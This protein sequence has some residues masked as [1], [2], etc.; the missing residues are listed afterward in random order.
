MYPQAKF[1]QPS[2]S[3][4]FSVPICTTVSGVNFTD[5]YDNNW[6]TTVELNFLFS[7]LFI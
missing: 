3:P 6:F 4:H 1:I 7:L 5:L 2:L